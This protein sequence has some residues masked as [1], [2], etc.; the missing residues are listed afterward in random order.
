MAAGARISSI[1][2]LRS[3][4]VISVLLLHVTQILRGSVYPE[5]FLLDGSFGVDIFF[6]ISGFI[7]SYSAE[8]CSGPIQ[9]MG[10]R[11]IRVAPTYWLL[12][13]LLFSIAYYAPDMLRSTKGD[14]YNL[15]KSL[16]FIPYVKESGSVQ[17]ILF[18]GWTLN[19]EMFFYALF[20]LSMG[21]TRRPAVLVTCAFVAMAIVGYTIHPEPV[22][23]AFYTSGIV[24]EFAAGIW[25]F[26]IYQARDFR[27][28]A[29]ASAFVPL[30]IGALVAQMAWP[31]PFPREVSFGIPAAVTVFGSLSWRMPEKGLASIAVI[32]G[33]AS[34]SLY[35]THPYVLNAV[36]KLVNR[37]FGQGLAQAVV[38]A[39]L[40]IASAICF[41]LLFYRYCER[42][43]HQWM[44][45]KMRK[46]LSGKVSPTARSRPVDL[47]FI[48]RRR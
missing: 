8:T 42:P 2:F 46:D 34:Y 30:G 28:F 32:L 1:Q 20:A 18:V 26:K 14:F 11:A 41:S 27:P 6:V 15:L 23:A 39:I 47:G 5:T 31:I 43:L 44:L 40:M 7:I 29:G 24:L 37:L 10:R 35:L 22:A 3:V 33:D 17:P 36:G 45:A 4:A 16:L 25:I 13:I 48:G 38:A 21:L 19:Y 9:F 12:T